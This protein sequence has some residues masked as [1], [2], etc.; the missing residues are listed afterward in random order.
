[1]ASA[2]RLGRKGGKITASPIIPTHALT[3]GSSTS[4]VSLHTPGEGTTIIGDPNA[5]HPFGSDM[6]TVTKK[7]T[8]AEA[9]VL[10]FDVGAIQL[11]GKGVVVGRAKQARTRTYQPQSDATEVRQ[12]LHGVFSTRRSKVPHRAASAGLDA[13]QESEVVATRKSQDTLSL[14][15]ALL[16]ADRMAN[17]LVVVS[18]YYELSHVRSSVEAILR[19]EGEDTQS[20]G[21]LFGQTFEGSKSTRAWVMTADMA[22]LYMTQLGSPAPF[23]HVVVPCCVDT[24]SSL[25]CFLKM[26]GGW[27]MS[28]TPRSQSVRLVVTTDCSSDG[29]VARTIGVPRVKILDDKVIRLHEFSY[30]EVCALLG[31][32]TMEMDKDAAGKFPSPPKRLVDYTADVAAELV[33]Y[34]VTHTP[35]AQIFSIFTADVREVL[36]ALQGAKIEDCTVYSTLKSAADKVETKHRVH[37]INHVSHALDTENEFTMVLDMGTIRRSSVQHKSE[38]FIAASTTEWESKAEQA[39]RKSILGENTTC[40]YFALFQDDVGASFQDEAQFLPDI[41]NV[42]NA[43]V[44]CARLNLS[45]CE[46]GR[47]LPSVPRDVVDQ[48]MQ[49]VAEKCMISTPDSLAITFL[50]EIKSRLPVEIDVAYLIMGGCS[51]GLG[52]ATLVVSAV[53]ALPFR[54]TAP[55]TYTVNRWTEATQESRKRCAGDIALSSDL[56][57][58]AFVFLEWL[59]LRTTGAATAAFLEAFLV[60]EFKF[61]K[62]EGLMNHMRD[63]LMNYAFLD[64]LDDVD[65]VNKVAESLRENASTMLM[66]LSMALSRRAAFIRD[67]GHINEK[68]RHASMVFVRTSKQLVV[69]PFIPSG[70]RWETGG[71]VIPVILKNSTTILGGMFSLVDTSLFFASLLLLYPQIEYSR[72]VTTERGRVVYFGVACN[73]QMKRFVVSIDDATQ[74]LDFRENINTAIGCMRALRMLPHPISKTR[75]AIALKEHDRFFDMERLHRETQRRLHSLAA[76]LNVQEHQGSFETFAKHYTAPKEIIPF[77]DVAATDVLL[78]RRFADGTLWDEQRPSPQSAP[79]IGSSPQKSA[80]L[81]PFDTAIPA[82]YDDDDDDVQIIQNSYFMLHGPLIEDDDD[83]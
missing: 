77:N 64:R 42:E 58:D 17:I 54:S 49:K 71:I 39:E 41:F 40:C 36:T 1:M 59:R 44:Q 48:V 57:A 15:A 80:V 12:R 2:P 62:I 45:V 3:P 74:I 29:H 53:I 60:Q 18:K 70:A 22:L 63:Q 35:T 72:P 50:G 37:V 55:P 20:V 51:L 21:V 68:D 34:V 52:E 43:F 46:V 28:N 33:R 19:E 23:T 47:L 76:A 14:V 56:L 78:L 67:A 8:S 4:P 73:W 81:T 65:T 26:L 7:Q 9:N 6:L 38:S 11:L 24:T 79:A 25:S 75:F 10:Q 5:A 16:S 66:L 31:K 30:N 61:E 13:L 69:H 27:M 83:D 32:Q 82:P